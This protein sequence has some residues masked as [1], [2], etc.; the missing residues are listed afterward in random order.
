MGG[1]EFVVLLPG[2]RPDDTE[3]K[4]RHFREMVARVGRDLFQEDLLTV[5]IGVAHF[6]I[7]GTD[8]EQLLAE[9]DRRMY[10]E[11][12]SQKPAMASLGGGSWD[13]SEWV[14]TVN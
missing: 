14:S 11:K 6:P 10:K 12:R 9:A 7:D 2:V 5:S 4:A 1:D 8:A 13:N 3:G